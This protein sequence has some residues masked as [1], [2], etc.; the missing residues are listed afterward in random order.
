MSTKFD[1]ITPGGFFHICDRAVGDELLF[2]RAEDYTDWMSR[3]EKFILPVAELHAYCLMNNHYHLLIR[4]LET[5]DH[6]LFSTQMSRLQ[7]TYAKDYNR[8]YD[9]KGGL[10]MRPFA[11][12]EIL[13]EAQLAW[14]FWYIHRNP[15]H[16]GI[17]LNWETWAYSSYPFYINNV[18][19]IIT[20]NFCTELFGGLEQLKAHH[21]MNANAFNTE[22][23]GFSL[24]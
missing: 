11:R 7:S 4:A 19:S 1:I 12:R 9:R 3:I 5:T 16:H 2:R 21:T 24:D 8:T 17:S 20:T 15:L 10:F 22:F 18:P 14:V 13:N 6:D 23:M